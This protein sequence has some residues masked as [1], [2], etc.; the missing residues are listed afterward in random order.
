MTTSTS[1]TNPSAAFAARIM[2]LNLRELAEAQIHRGINVAPISHRDVLAA[3][4]QQSSPFTVRRAP[5]PTG[6]DA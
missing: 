1:H 2:T 6:R 4:A 3:A 5:M